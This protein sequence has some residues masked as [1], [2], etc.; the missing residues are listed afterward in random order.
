[1]KFKH[2]TREQKILTELRRLKMQAGQ[3]APKIEAE[4]KE[5]KTHE[6]QTTPEK[7]SE[8]IQ[9]SIPETIVSPPVKPD[10][11]QH[12]AS[13]IDYSY[14]FKDLRKTLILATGAILVQVG[15]SLTL[16]LPYA[17]LILRTL[18]LDF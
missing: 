15:L 18:N 12:E 5:E 10:L 16:K 14:V 3:Y 11:T 2:K 1:M 7:P 8:K 6:T 9:F 13:S 17:K 4:I